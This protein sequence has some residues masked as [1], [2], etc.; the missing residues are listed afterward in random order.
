M[1]SASM[2]TL[3]SP[4]AKFGLC[5]VI[6]FLIALDAL[7]IVP[8]SA[9]MV[10]SSGTNPSNSGLLVSAY[11]IAAAFTCLWVRGTGNLSKEKYKVFIFLSATTL[12]TL[13]TSALDSFYILLFVRA[14]TGICGG[15]LVVLNLNLVIQISH[16]NDK[17]KDT[18]IL[19]SAFPLAL[20]IG[21]PALLAIT[22]NQGW[23]LGFMILG[24]GLAITALLFTFIFLSNIK[25]AS[26]SSTNSDSNPMSSNAFHPTKTLKYALFIAFFVVLSTFAISTQFPVMLII[27]LSISSSMLSACYLLSGVCS[28]IAVQLY[29]RRKLNNHTTSYLIYFLS[30]LMILAALFGFT[31]SSVIFAAGLFTLFVITSATRSMILVTELIT[32]LH[33]EERSTFIS[34]QNA[35]QHFAIASGGTIASLLVMPHENHSLNFNVLIVVSTLLIVITVVMWRNFQR[36]RF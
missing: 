29:A 36:K 11:A 6:H 30:G 4:K 1:F 7:I 5:F 21:I 18:A 23:Q 8:F 27:N 14:L 26:Q 35:I 15:A 24:S 19:L 13:L 12:L 2:T 32:S 22:A 31:I 9:E 28:F 34:L 10:L 3:A 33:A 20:A 17:K 25:Q 16:E